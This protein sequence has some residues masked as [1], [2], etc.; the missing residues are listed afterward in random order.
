MHCAVVVFWY[1]AKG[2]FGAM[3]PKELAAVPGEAPRPTKFSPAKGPGTVVDM[4]AYFSESADELDRDAATLVWHEKGVVLG[5]VPERT[6]TIIYRPTPVR[7]S[8]AMPGHLPSRPRFSRG[9][10]T[11]S[12]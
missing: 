2:I 5:S 11:A 12:T 10:A 3:A 8:G 1:I 4:W 7:C 9:R 6:T